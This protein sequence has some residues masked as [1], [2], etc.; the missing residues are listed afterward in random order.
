MN[1]KGTHRTDGLRRTNQEGTGNKTPWTGGGGG[2]GPSWTCP[3][4][5]DILS[6]RSRPGF[7][8]VGGI[9]AAFSSH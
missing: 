6:W 9:L 3:T 2:F 8:P 4:R 7:S 5:H 1:H